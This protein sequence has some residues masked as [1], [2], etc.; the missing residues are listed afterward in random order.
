MVLFDELHQSGLMSVQPMWQ[1]LTTTT[2]LLIS[3]TAVNVLRKARALVCVCLQR[4]NYERI[5]QCLLM[6]PNADISVFQPF[7]I[8]EKILYPIDNPT[9]IL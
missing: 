7:H 1:C 3:M 2:I 4:D 5:E 6:D 8:T 9:I